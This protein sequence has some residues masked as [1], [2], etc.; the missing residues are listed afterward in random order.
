MNFKLLV[1]LG[2]AVEFVWCVENAVLARSEDLLGKLR[3]DA[4]GGPKWAVSGPKMVFSGPK[5]T[6]KR[7]S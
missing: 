6:Q 2:S 7:P 3:G 1:F 4:A 5:M